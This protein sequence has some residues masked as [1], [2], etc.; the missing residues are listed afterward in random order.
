MRAVS[1]RGLLSM[2]GVRAVLPASGSLSAL[3]R[4]SRG[5]EACSTSSAK[6]PSPALLTF[7]LR[8]LMWR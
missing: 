2:K 3:T 5:E 7:S 6:A 4:R 8:S 1:Q